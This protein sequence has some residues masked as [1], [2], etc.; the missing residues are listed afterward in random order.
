MRTAGGAAGIAIPA[1]GPG[2]FATDE[3]PMIHPEPGIQ[4]FVP[5]GGSVEGAALNASVTGSR[6]RLAFSCASMTAA[7]SMRFE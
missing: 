1:S 3:V 4:L 5:E 2:V 7:A 6:T